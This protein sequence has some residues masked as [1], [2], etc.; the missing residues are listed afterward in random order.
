MLAAPD[1]VAFRRVNDI[2][3]AI[4][5]GCDILLGVEKLTL[6]A[7]NV[8]TGGDLL[9]VTELSRILGVGRPLIRRLIHDGRLRAINLGSGEAGLP[10]FKVR[11]AELDRFLAD[12]EAGR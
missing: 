1:L 9:T 12:R 2:S 5:I 7:P 8:T 10:Y 3:R 4:A 11:R 6:T